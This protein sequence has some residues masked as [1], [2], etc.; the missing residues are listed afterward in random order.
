MREPAV[1]NF[2]ASWI[3]KENA[4][5]QKELAG[6]KK[7]RTPGSVGNTTTSERRQRQ[8]RD[9]RDGFRGLHVSKFV[10]RCGRAVKF[11]EFVD[12]SVPGEVC[13]GGN[14]RQSFA[15]LRTG[16]SFSRIHASKRRSGCPRL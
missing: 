15:N 8:C 14:G 10:L 7:S 12:Q 16:K 5:V 9:S 13:N 2:V 4:P 6:K 3:G 1:G 11:P